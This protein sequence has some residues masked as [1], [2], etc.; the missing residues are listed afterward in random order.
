[1]TVKKVLVVDDSATDLKNLEQICSGAGYA[2]VTASSGSEAVEKVSSEQPDAVL[3]DVI[4][5]DMNGFQVCRAITSNSATQHIPV[6]LV[7]S[8]GEK[9][10]RIWGEQQGAKAYI[11]KPYTPEQILNQLALL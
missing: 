11:I 1:M 8:K 7:S 5:N 9:T 10:D 6:V 3:L 4:M 2:V